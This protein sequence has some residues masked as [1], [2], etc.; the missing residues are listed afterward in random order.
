MFVVG[1]HNVTHPALRGL[2]GFVRTPLHLQVAYK[3]VHLEELADGVSKQQHGDDTTTDIYHTDPLSNDATSFGR[4]EKA[5]LTSRA[6]AESAQTTMATTGL[7]PLL[8]WLLM[9]YYMDHS[10]NL[11]RLK[12]MA[13]GRHRLEP[14]PSLQ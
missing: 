2:F 10:Y 12:T 3:A 4:L 11:A 5:Q 13:C 6:A 1:S 9:P 7:L 8:G 14:S